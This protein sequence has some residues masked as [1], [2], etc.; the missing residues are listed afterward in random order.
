MHITTNILLFCSQEWMT[1]ITQTLI[2]N[3]QKCLLVLALNYQ[4]AARLSVYLVAGR[5][6]IIGRRRLY[7]LLSQ[8]PASNGFARWDQKD[9]FLD[10]GGA[11]RAYLRA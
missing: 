8:F 2:H 9:K 6:A 10:G 1:A 3:K 7:C 11:G 4:Q 5:M